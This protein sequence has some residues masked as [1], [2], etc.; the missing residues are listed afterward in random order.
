M[1]SS[2]PR[3]AFPVLVIGGSLCLVLLGFFVGYLWPA[4]RPEPRNMRL[5]TAP[6]SQPAQS[7][8]TAST[9]PEIAV[10][11]SGDLQQSVPPNWTF[12][13]PDGKL[14]DAPDLQGASAT[15]MFLIRSFATHGSVQLIAYKVSDLSSLTAWLQKE[16]YPTLEVGKR[17]VTVI[18]MDI[19][20]TKGLLAIGAS[21]AVIFVGDPPWSK[22]PSLMDGEVRDL[23]QSIHVQ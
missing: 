22:D 21:S 4:R 20:G 6:P 5:P 18:P 7:A 13:Q 11:T 3:V 14:W 17:H 15:D 1:S 16:K 2:R 23:V 10:A 12:V 9:L 19:S 8:P